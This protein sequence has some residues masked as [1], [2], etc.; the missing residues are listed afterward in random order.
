[1]LYAAVQFETKVAKSSQNWLMEMECKSMCMH[2][3][4]VDGLQTELEKQMNTTARPVV[5]VENKYLQA[6][7]EEVVWGEVKL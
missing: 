2:N 3:S 5:E 6:P 4:K 7:G 1:M